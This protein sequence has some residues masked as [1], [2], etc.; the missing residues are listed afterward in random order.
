MQPLKLLLMRNPIIEIHR[1]VHHYLQN[2][3]YTFHLK[4]ILT[5][6]RYKFYQVTK[7]SHELCIIGFFFQDTH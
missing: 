6:D 2:V 3:M 1:L 4:I 7:I 5:N